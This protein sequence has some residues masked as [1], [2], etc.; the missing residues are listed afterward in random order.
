M[1]KTLTPDQLSD[2][3]VQLNRGHRSRFRH[4]RIGSQ[5]K[6]RRFTGE[7]I[8]GSITNMDDMAVS[9]DNGL[10]AASGTEQ[11]SVAWS[12]ILSEEN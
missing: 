2:Y 4:F 9:L 6:V 8:E 12:E 5:V 10:H 11:W 3:I 1:S 7:V